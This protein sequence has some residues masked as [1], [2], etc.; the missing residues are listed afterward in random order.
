ML[1][2]L[3]AQSKSCNIGS[4]IVSKN[5][6]TFDSCSGKENNQIDR[7]T[8]CLNEEDYLIGKEEK[9]HQKSNAG[10]CHCAIFLRSNAI[11]KEA[12]SAAAQNPD[13]IWVGNI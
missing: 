10:Y 4:Q 6:I 7:T 2:Y 3:N 1:E 5:S 13:P 11:G 12:F 8:T 9:C